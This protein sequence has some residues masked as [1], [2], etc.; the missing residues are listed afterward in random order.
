[1]I[2]AFTIHT[3]PLSICI[4]P[5]IGFSLLFHFQANITSGVLISL[6]FMTIISTHQSDY[7]ITWIRIDEVANWQVPRPILSFCFVQEEP[8]WDMVSI[9]RKIFSIK[10]RKLPLKDS[11]EVLR[12]LLWGVRLYHHV[13]YS[14]WSIA[15][16]PQHQDDSLPCDT[17]FWRESQLFKWKSLSTYHYIVSEPQYMSCTRRNSELPYSMSWKQKKKKLYK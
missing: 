6:I 16:L 7:I 12:S 11:Q 1:M 15:H 9:H 13:G 14:S 2:T 5:L 4:S 17:L 10:G 3:P 8:S